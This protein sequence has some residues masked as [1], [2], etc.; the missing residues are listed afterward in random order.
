MNWVVPLEG[1]VKS[2]LSFEV[3]K[4]HLARRLVPRLVGSGRRGNGIGG[5]TYAHLGVAQLSG[6]IVDL[7]GV[8]V[9]MMRKLEIGTLTAR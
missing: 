8:G 4:H 6:R 5:T 1:L 7:V 3:V 2:G 9:E